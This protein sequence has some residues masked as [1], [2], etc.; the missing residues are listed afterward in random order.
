MLVTKAAFTPGTAEAQA[1]LYPAGISGKASGFI[2]FMLNERARELLGEFHRWEDLSRTKMLVIK[3]KAFNEEA[4]ANIS[5]K[6]LYRPIPQS[7]LDANRVGEVPLSSAEKTAES[8]LVSSRALKFLQHNKRL[9]ILS[10]ISLLCVLTV[11]WLLK[12][13]LKND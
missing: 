10:M 6:H 11:S 1:E 5:E 2:N 9:I 4:A 13:L 7:F 3:T 12:P 8:R